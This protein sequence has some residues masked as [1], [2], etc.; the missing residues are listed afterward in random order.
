M[1]GQNIDSLRSLLNNKISDT[2][3][4]NIHHKISAELIHTDPAESFKYA[5]SALSLSKKANSDKHL[6]DSYNNLGLI[7]SYGSDDSAIVYYLKARDIKQKLN[8]VKGIAGTYIKIGSC[9]DKL[10][11]KEQALAYYIKSLKLFDSLSIESG[12]ASACLGMGNI[13]NDLRNYSKAIEYYNRSVEMYTK[14]NSPYRS[15]ALNNL[16]GC[17]NRIGNRKKAMELYEESLR[18]KLEGKDF[19]GAVFSIDNIGN[20]LLEEG[21]FKEALA[22]FTRAL[23][24]NRQNDLE[25]ETF[26]NSY[27]SIAN[28]LLKMDRHSLAKRYIDSLGITLQHLS[29]HQLRLSYL[30]LS[31][32]YYENIQ[33]Y[34]SA[35]LY[36]SRFLTLKDS[37]LN[38]EVNQ[39]IAEADA[40]YANEKKQKDIELLQKDK[41][42]QQ[43]AMDKQQVQRNGFIAGFVAVVILLVFIFRG[44]RQK[45]KANILITQQKQEVER[46]K[47][48]VDEHQKEILDSI[49]YAKRIQTTLMAHTDFVNENIP[50]NFILFKP[51]DIV[52][53]DF[54]WGTKHKDLF[55]LA[56]CDSTG[57]GVPGAFMSLLNINFLGEAINEKN[58]IEP[59]KVFNYVR[60]RLIDEISKEGQKDGFDGIL[61]CLDQR[62]NKITYAAAN[63]APIVIRNG[64]ILELEKDRMPVGKGEKT[65]SFTLHH[66]DLQKEDSLYLY[67]DGYADQFG[68]PKGKKFL[69]KRLNELLQSLNPDELSKRGDKLNYKFEEW[70]GG[71]EQVDDVLVIGIKI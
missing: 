66:I 27:N 9:F 19:Y 57:H 44:Y 59:H 10:G 68:G 15:W 51:K 45:Q 26:A 38:S 47:Y 40:R 5:F 25:K 7:H 65:D 4:I 55:Y 20:I 70:K 54:Y 49:H 30:R 62:T 43:I 3:R 13:F 32:E 1:F 36:K 60:Q 64:E 34:K 29:F 35:F 56:V 63:N 53:G 11:N 18:L 46:Q 22:N 33:D 6:A 21:K 50:N 37:L 69:Y 2:S 52:S 23:E 24:I 48:L 17:Y 41:A 8:D 67:T 58:I 61:I 71:L 12:I 14:I 16:A 28:A 42:I 31:S 39:Q